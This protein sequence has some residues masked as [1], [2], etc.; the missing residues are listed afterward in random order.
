[1]ESLNFIHDVNVMRKTLKTVYA[2]SEGLKALNGERGTGPGNCRIQ[3]LPVCWRHLLEFP[4]QRG[5]KDE[6]DLGLE[7]EDEDTCE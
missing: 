6:Q 2:S 1:M 7:V 5:T 3:V 4:R